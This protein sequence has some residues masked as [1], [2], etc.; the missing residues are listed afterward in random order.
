FVMHPDWNLKTLCAREAQ[1]A[2]ESYITENCE[3]AERPTG[4]PSTCKPLNSWKPRMLLCMKRPAGGWVARSG[5]SGPVNRADESCLTRRLRI[6]L[7]RPELPLL[8]R[9]PPCDSEVPAQWVR[10]LK[11][12]P[13]PHLP[14]H[15]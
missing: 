12:A 14:L 10:W 13:C 3:K 11:C 4:F 8:L 15:C 1:R 9:R 6:P 2:Q 5:S 7:R